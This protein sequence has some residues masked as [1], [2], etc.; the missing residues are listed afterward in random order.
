MRT[1]W[2][3]A[4]LIWDLTR[5]TSPLYGRKITNLPKKRRGREESVFILNRLFLLVAKL[6]SKVEK[7]SR[8]CIASFSVKIIRL[9]FKSSDI[10]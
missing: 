6:K 2:C 7:N 4:A 10:N 3:Y 1:M 8:Q 9:V 5:M